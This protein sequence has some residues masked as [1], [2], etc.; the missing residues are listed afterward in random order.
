MYNLD[1]YNLKHAAVTGVAISAAVAGYSIYQ[2]EKKKKE[3]EVAHKNIDIPT[4]E[5]VYQDLPISTVGSDFLKEQN[6]R[7]T[8]QLVG[9]SRNAGIRGVL[10]AVPKI[11][12]FS[13]DANREGQAYLDNQV[14]DRNRLIASDNQRIQGMEE[15]RYNA[16]LAGI[17]Q[18]MEVG[19]AYTDQGI[20]GLR[21]TA[22]SGAKNIEAG[23]N[24]GTEYFQT[25]S[26]ES[27]N[28]R[29]LQGYGSI[30]EYNAIP[31]LMSEQ[32]PSVGKDS[33]LYT[34]YKPDAY[35][36]G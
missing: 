35:G 3:A 21:N 17:G 30:R 26:L 2:G 32:K 10:S 29:L 16:E 34:N 14:Q 36:L 11:Q 12:S 33:N 13:N 19:Q 18:L 7:T 27:I 25:E 9:A 6:S 20:R 31:K 5:N 4:L 1:K 15:Q 28:K 24:Q 8:S 22:I 23:R